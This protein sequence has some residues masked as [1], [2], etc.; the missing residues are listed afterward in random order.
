VTS[1]VRPA[2]SVAATFRDR[3]DRPPRLIAR[4]PGR[5]NLLGGH[6]DY[7]EGWVLPAA[8]DRGL[9]FAAAARNDSR[10]RI[11]AVD[12]EGEVELDLDALPPPLAQRP[13]RRA[14]WHDVPAAVAWACREHSLPLPGLDLAF[15]GDLPIGAGVSSSAAVEVGLLLLWDL[16]GGWQLD[17]GALATLGQRAENGYLEVASGIMDQFAILHGRAEHALLLDC[18]TFEFEAVPLP[19]DCAVLVFDSGIRRQLSDSSYNDRRAECRLAVES[20]NQ[21]GFV[22]STLRDLPLVDLDRALGSLD[23]TA[24]QRVRHVVEECARVRTAA[25][26]LSAGDVQGLGRAMTASHASA[27]R[28]YDISLPEL[29][30]LAEAADSSPGCYGARLTGAGFGGCVTALARADRSSAVTA[31]V[32]EAFERVYDRRPLSFECRVADAARAWYG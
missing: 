8:I 24:A 9:D 11:V 22:L 7:Q 30:L 12:V 18:R 13:D 28:L 27:R 32:T 17:R 14:A 3:F 6:L 10:L 1:P 23:S 15:G 5:V 16:L 4:A 21:S 2:T 31:S 25:N 19:E 26:G 29:D 20:L